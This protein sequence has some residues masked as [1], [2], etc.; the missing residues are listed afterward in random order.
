MSTIG[1]LKPCPICK[2]AVELDRM[3]LDIYR[4]RHVGVANCGLCRIR[5]FADTEDDAINLWNNWDTNKV[6]PVDGYLKLSDID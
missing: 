2:R 1:K 3:Q 4:V 5:V 6:A